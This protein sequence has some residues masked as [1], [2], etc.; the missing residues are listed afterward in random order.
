MA[1]RVQHIVRGAGVAVVAARSDLARHVGAVVLGI[2]DA[3]TIA[4][5]A[6]RAHTLAARVQH[7]VRGAGVAIVA[8]RSDLACHVRAVV[9]RVADA[10]AIAVRAG[11]AQALAA[12]VPRIVHR[13]GVAIG[14][15]CS[16]HSRSSGHPRTIRCRCSRSHGHRTQREVL[17][18]TT[19]ADLVLHRPY[20]ELTSGDERNGR[21]QIGCL[22]DRCRCKPARGLRRRIDHVHMVSIHRIGRSRPAERCHATRIRDSEVG[23]RC[24]HVHT[25]AGIA[26]QGQVC[27]AHR[28]LPTLCLGHVEA[29]IVHRGQGTRTDRFPHTHMVEI[30]CRDRSPTIRQGLSAGQW[31]AQE[32]VLVVPIS[33]VATESHV[34]HTTHAH[35]CGVVLCC[36]HIVRTI[37]REHTSFVPLGTATGGIGPEVA[38]PVHIGVERTAIRIRFGDV[39]RTHQ[40]CDVAPSASRQWIAHPLKVVEDDTPDLRGPRL[41]L[42]LMHLVQVGAHELCLAL[43]E[44]RHVVHVHTTHLQ[45]KCR[46]KAAVVE[47]PIPGDVPVLHTLCTTAV[48][49]VVRPC[50]ID[51]PIVPVTWPCSGVFT[52]PIRADVPGVRHRHV[53]DDVDRFH[54][55]GIT[56]VVVDDHVAYSGDRSRA[57]HIGTQHHPTIG[58]Q[59]RSELLQFRGQRPC[60]LIIDKEHHLPPVVLQG[61][62]HAGTDVAIAGAAGCA[63]HDPVF[64]SHTGRNGIIRVGC[65]RS[66]WCGKRRSPT[67][68]GPQLP[69]DGERIGVRMRRP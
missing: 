8:A 49:A 35:R 61:N 18:P 34:E 51:I 53:A 29:R 6:G 2:A 24:D 5:R 50:A 23:R 67:G 44:C 9:L 25:Q 12:R 69:I 59:V 38:L 63:P 7:I 15:S 11:R 45:F 21:I 39:R 3:V 64:I 17:V 55:G 16:W 54:I 40:G 47:L 46:W 60:Q 31:C 37:E 32:V 22:D 43:S 41:Q 4:V 65:C 52:M 36:R 62:V 66:G 30:P 27:L 10:V 28:A 33:E 13:T 57:A 68:G 58:T 56:V 48:D 42:E 26:H 20:H 19:V 1:A 14:A